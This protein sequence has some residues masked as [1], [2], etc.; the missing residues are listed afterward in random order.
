MLRGERRAQRA[1]V[2]V[3]GNHAGGRARSSSPAPNQ[4]K[5]VFW[6]LAKNALKAMPEGGTLTDRPSSR[7]GGAL[8][9]RF[10]DTGIGMTEEDK[11]HIFEPFYSGFEN[12]RGLGMAVVRRIV[13]DYDGTIEVR[14]ELG[15]GH[16]DPHHPALREPGRPPVRSSN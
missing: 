15:Q 4:F 13:D 11:A 14:S 6:N 7:T 12:G 5:Q 8:R 3:G 2:V 10:A 9:I 16:R 1:R